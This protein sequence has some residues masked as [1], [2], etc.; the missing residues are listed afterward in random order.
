MNYKNNKIIVSYHKD[1][2]DSKIPLQTG[3]LYLLHCHNTA[4][5]NKATTQHWLIP[6]WCLEEGYI[7]H[8]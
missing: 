2:Y 8:E 7:T 5:S 6:K 3:D 1:V 4:Y